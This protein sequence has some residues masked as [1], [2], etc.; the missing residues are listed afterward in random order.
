MDIFATLALFMNPDIS[1][2]LLLIAVPRF[3]MALGG[4]PFLLRRR[5][6]H[7]VVYHAEAKDRM[8]H[9][10]LKLASGIRTWARVSAQSCRVGVRGSPLEGHN[11]HSM[12]SVAY[13]VQMD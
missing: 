2:R 11:T 5:T 12:E 10:F 7:N 4:T 8:E 9:L 1:I 3:S 6:C 13:S